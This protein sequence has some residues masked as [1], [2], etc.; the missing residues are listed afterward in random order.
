MLKN[1]FLTWEEDSHS[2]IYDVLVSR[3]AAIIPPTVVVVV[4]VI[5]L[6]VYIGK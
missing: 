5:V 1:D 4:V 6:V 3:G 2:S